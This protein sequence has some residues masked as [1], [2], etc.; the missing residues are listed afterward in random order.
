MPDVPL[1][2]IFLAL[3]AIN[4]ACAA[5]FWFDKQAAIAGRRR[6]PEAK[7]LGYALIGG[8]PGAFFARYVFRHKTRKQPFSFNLWLIAALQA[9]GGL[10]WLIL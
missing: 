4:V 8:T 3:I 2:A 6:V 9:G 10:G 1:S 7:L 5:L